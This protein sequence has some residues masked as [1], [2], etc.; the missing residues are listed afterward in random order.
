[1][2]FWIFWEGSQDGQHVKILK[3]DEGSVGI[4]PQGQLWCLLFKCIQYK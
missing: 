2:I 3:G 1:M 4:S